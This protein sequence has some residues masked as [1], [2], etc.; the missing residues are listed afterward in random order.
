MPKLS[1]WFWFFCILL[2]GIAWFALTQIRLGDGTALID[3][4]FGR[5]ISFKTPR[6]PSVWRAR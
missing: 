3:A 5:S 2:S 1:V 4:G 6:G